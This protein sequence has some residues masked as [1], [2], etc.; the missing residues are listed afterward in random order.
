VTRPDTE[1]A[2]GTDAVVLAWG[3]GRHVAGIGRPGADFARWSVPARIAR[4]AVDHPGRVAV[5]YE[6]ETLSY[7][8]LISR[9]R[10]WGRLLRDA[11]A[12][13]GHTVAVCLDRGP[14]TIIVMMAAWEAGAAYVPLDPDHPTRRLDGIIADAAPSVL[15]TTSALAEQLHPPEGTAVV[16]VDDVELDAIAEPPPA[17]HP[18][19][20]DLAYVIYTSGSTG[21]PK[22][23]MIE[24]GGLANLVEGLLSGAG[25][26]AADRMLAVVPFSFD[27]SG[28]DIYVT[29]AGGAML[30]IA[31]EAAAGDPELLCSLLA[32]HR[33]TVCQAT[34]STWRLYAALPRRRPPTLRRI[35]CGG[36]D[37]P[38]AL[39][40]TLAEDGVEIHNL[41]G[42]TETTIC[43]VYGRV[44][45]DPVEKISSIGAPIV[46]TRAYVVDDGG[47]LLAPG[48]EGE[49][50]I[51]GAGVARGYLRRDDLT[52]ERFLP[53]PF[54][55]DGRVYRTGDLAAWNENGT[56][57]YLGR[58]DQQVKIRGSRVELGEIDAV[59]YA[60]P[61]VAAALTLTRPDTSGQQQLVAYVVGAPGRLLEPGQLRQ[62]LMRDLPDYMIPADLV[63]IEEF[64]LNANGKVDHAALHAMR[65]RAR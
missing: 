65:E 31:P 3:T 16:H 34:P 11:G 47:R 41:Y 32:E 22:G 5:A 62:T 21:R 51:G 9:V 54:V 53:D 52:R 15:V 13:P 14:Q 12:R 4:I 23:V 44:P 35:W 36:E 50:W 30:V 1:P 33:I 38:A 6:G 59:L 61:D 48:L 45:T 10:R 25:M 29:L 60:H 26:D 17:P 8:E 19:P 39:V 49:L 7:A 20:G 46:N 55:A 56:L 37:L 28:T 2:A 24:H 27:M 58:I 43:C 42:P 40:E 64:P 63:V 18:G 57:R